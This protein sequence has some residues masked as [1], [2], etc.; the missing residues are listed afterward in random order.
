MH[1]VE[2]EAQRRAVAA[3]NEVLLYDVTNTYFEGQVE[4]THKRTLAARLRSFVARLHQDHEPVMTLHRATE[5][6]KAN[7]KTLS[8]IP[9]PNRRDKL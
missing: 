3:Q 9:S 2:L 7:V 8:L 6:A 4:D 5:R 1:N